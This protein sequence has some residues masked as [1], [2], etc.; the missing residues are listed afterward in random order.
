MTDTAN[1]PPPDPNDPNRGA[2]G[3]SGELNAVVVHA[4]GSKEQVGTKSLFARI[5]GWFSK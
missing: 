2:M 3:A 5:A 4:D 1:T